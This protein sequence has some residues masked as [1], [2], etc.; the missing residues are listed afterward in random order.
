MHGKETLAQEPLRRMLGARVMAPFNVDTDQFGS[1]GGTFT[2]ELGVRANAQAKARTGVR[3][4][5]P[6]AEVRAE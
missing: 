4:G 1:Y 6:V 2:R 5:Q 3:P